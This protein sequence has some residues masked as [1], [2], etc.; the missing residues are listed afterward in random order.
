MVQGMAGRPGRWRR[1]VGRPDAGDQRCVV[2][3]RRRVGPV[4][5]ADAT[6]GVHGRFIRSGVG[7]AEIHT[8]HAAI[9]LQADGA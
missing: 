3:G 7:A 5:A 9:V 4:H 8:C 2:V 6:T 1:R